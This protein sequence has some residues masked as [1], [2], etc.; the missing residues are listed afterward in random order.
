MKKLKI[1]GLSKNEERAKALGLNPAPAI[2][3]YF[4]G[5]EKSEEII[6]HNAAG[7][8]PKYLGF[9]IETIER[10]NLNCW[11][12]YSYS[13]KSPEQKIGIENMKRAV[14]VA[15]EHGVE[16][17]I[18]AGKGEPLLDQNLMPLVR[19]VSE[20]GL[21]FVLFTNNTL[22]TPEIAS[23]LYRLNTSV[24]AKLGSLDAQKQD[25]I[26]DVVGAHKAI[27]NG[28]G[29]LVNAGFSE[30]RLA[31]DVTITKENIGEMEE[32][33]GYLRRRSIIPYLEPLIENGKA[34]ENEERLE[35]AR[36]SREELE[37]LFLRLR[38]IDE[39]E[40]G[41]TW[42][43]SEDVRSPGAEGCSKNLTT[44]T[45]RQNG[46]VSACVNELDLSVGNVFENDFEEIV[47]GPALKKIR[48]ECA[49][50]QCKNCGVRI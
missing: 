9:Y 30:P 42:A 46:D 34:L 6:K 31:A 41:Y 32:I 20:K 16:S 18:V 14:D 27:M 8:N 3:G 25:S 5:K 47:E 1:N 33:W 28:L 10:C 44:L 12:C 43:I 40:F 11:F 4:F 39:D 38:R 36:V 26:V 24:I 17:V 7:G 21:R 29:V 19:Y 50:C 37:G 15:A 22:I 45:L 48:S 23:E 49:K 2:K 13:K 35:K